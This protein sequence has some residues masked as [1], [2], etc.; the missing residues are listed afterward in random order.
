MPGD[1]VDAYGASPH[2][3]GRNEVVVNLAHG[4]GRDGEADAVIRI[5]VGG[6]GG[7][8]PN[9]LAGQIHQRTTAVARVDGGVCLEVV[10]ELALGTGFNAAAF[11]ADN[12]GC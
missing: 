6:D 4:V 10:L 5:M 2:L 1:E 3:P 12:A 9:H 11:S 8:D 7:V